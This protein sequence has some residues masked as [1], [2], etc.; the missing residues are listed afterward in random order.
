MTD[1]ETPQ[2][3]LEAYLQARVMALEEALRIAR[4]TTDTAIVM[5]VPLN[6]LQDEGFFITRMR[7]SA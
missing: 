7:P 2:T 6:S 1:R 3:A 5:K 4:G